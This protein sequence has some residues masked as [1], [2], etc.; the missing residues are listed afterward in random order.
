MRAVFTPC[1][2]MVQN[3]TPLQHNSTLFISPQLNR[4]QNIFI[5]PPNPQS[6]LFETP[7]SLLSLFY[8]PD[9]VGSHRPSSGEPPDAVVGDEPLS[10]AEKLRLWRHDAL[11]QHQYET[12]EYIGDKILS[13]TNDANDAFWLAQVYFNRGN[14]LR[15][16]KLLASKPE[17][18]QS[19]SCRTLSAHALIKLERWDDA[20]DLLGETNP[21]KDY[22]YK[23]RNTDGGVKLEAS[24]CYLR[25]LIYANQNNYERAQEAYKEAVMVDVKCFEAFNELI[26]NDYLSPSEQWDFIN[27][28]NYADADDNDELIKLLYTSRLSKYMNIP[29]FEEAESILKD[30]YR[31]GDNADL[32]LARADYLY[33]KC[34]YDECLAICEKV[35]E[36]DSCN[37]SLL[38]NYLSCLFELGGR[39]KLFLKADQ[40]ADNHPTHPLTW[41][42]I[43]IYYFSINKII[44]ARKYFS[45]VT[46]LNP[47][48]GQAWIGFAHTFALEG[49]HE[50]AISAYAFAA[51][52]FPG[53]HLPNLFLGMQ[54]LQ[55]NNVNLAEEYL[56]SSYQICNTDPLL[57]NELGVINYH[58]NS[59]S[60]AEAYFQEALAAAK[61][62]NSG[63]KTWI[64]IHSNLGHVYRRANQAH[65]ALDCF[66]Q[67]LKLSH[68]S[69]VNI[70]SSMGLVY[71]TL[72]NHHKAI[73]VLHDALAIMPTDQVAADLLKRA[74]ESN[75]N[76]SSLFMDDM[77]SKMSDI[78]ISANKLRFRESSNSRANHLMD[79]TTT[80]NKFA[81]PLTKKTRNVLERPLRNRANLATG[82]DVEALAEELKRGE[83]SSDEEV[84]DIESE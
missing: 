27:Q 51:R 62:L 69:N 48:S 79:I 81:T 26:G 58:K 19:L 52:L 54:H 11:N 25:G 30:E 2:T 7:G 23:V 47:N 84:M 16:H 66:N 10:R 32:L 59:L 37:F 13:M 82:G 45:K 21:F 55:M 22:N 71:M 61:Y 20:L 78:H 1:Y 8:N 68:R 80:N 64:S 41:V 29:K 73:R 70:L 5:T 42:A 39:N 24:M 28:L 63:S 46:V 33:V 60:R 56:F 75:K 44:E 17:Y 53:T 36:H 77:D 14:Y 15:A 40:L 74:L 31:M 72:G 12:A 43:G 4:R 6:N 9:N 65:K 83:V 3:K 34:N 50:Q 38:P 49:E 76:N 18:E 67:A 35:L 57:L